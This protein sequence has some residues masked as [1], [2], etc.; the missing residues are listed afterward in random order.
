[1]VIQNF[2]QFR[3]ALSENPLSQSTRKALIDFVEGAGSIEDVDAILA[4]AELPD[5]LRDT[6]LRRKQLLQQNNPPNGPSL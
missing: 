2:G 5:W 3:A 4:I 1:M 6:A